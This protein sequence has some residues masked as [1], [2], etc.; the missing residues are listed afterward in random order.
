MNKKTYAVILIILSEI[1]KLAVL[2]N[3]LVPWTV[4]SPLMIAFPLTSKSVDGKKLSPIPI[5][6]LEFIIILWIP[7]VT[8]FSSSLS[9]LGFVSA[10]INVSLS[11]SV[12]PDNGAQLYPSQ[13]SNISVWEL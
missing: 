5:C 11:I 2:T 4:K 9:S 6:P 8:N 7:F 10:E 1:S 3:V 12:R 13:P